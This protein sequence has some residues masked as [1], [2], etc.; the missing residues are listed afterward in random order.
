MLTLLQIRDFAIVEAVE[1]QFRPGFTALTGET[2][3]GKSILVDA[4]LLAIG[5]RGDSTVVRHGA[6]RTQI[7]AGFDV[8]GNAAA[9]AWLEEQSIDVQ[10]ECLLRR[11]VGTDGRS[12]AW[13]NGQSMPI[14]ALR[15][16]GDLLVEVHGQL[17]FQSLARRGYQR[18]LLDA[19]GDLA[20]EA[21]AVRAAW[22]EWRSAEAARVD[23]A[24]RARDREAR[25]DLLTHYVAELDALD[26]G[27]DEAADLQQERRRGA[28]LG[29]LAEGA[30]RLQD[31]LGVEGDGA[32]GALGRSQAL[33]RP[34][35]VL[36]ES[37]GDAQ[38]LVDEAAIACREA[39]G[40]L[41]HFA[42]SLN[43]DPTRLETVEARLSAFEATARKHRVD[44]AELPALR[45]RLAGELAELSDAG[46]HLAGLE[47]RVEQ[48]LTQYHAAARELT[49]GR[50]GAAVRLDATITALMQGLGMGGGVF[51]TRIEVPDPPPVGEHGADEIEFEVSANPGQPLRALARVA[52]GG[53]LSRMSLA[54]QVATLGADRPP[55]L[56]FDEVDA[57]VGGAVAE[58][59]G[60]SA[61]C[62]GPDGPGAVRNAPGAGRRT[63]RPADARRQAHRRLHDAHLTGDAR[64]RVTGPGDRPDARWRA[65]DGSDSRPRPRD[66]RGRARGRSGAAAYFRCK[67]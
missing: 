25:L 30:A 17:E 64:R 46:L 58:M 2:G 34:L 57:G 37:L 35:V 67:R 51:T 52:S 9:R 59:V 13:I 31:L 65:P 4:L 32:A 28:S 20:A 62:P 39:L 54:L 19:S 50:R 22:Q 10:E 44:V 43:A 41:A 55:C 15:E 48:A 60:R 23:L 11:V 66:A 45:V 47:R 6:E 38:R 8:S 27:P 42:D 53:E 7:T 21:S 56:V 33:L 26:P 36:D 63:G 12:R 5:G 24:R 16:L 40:S 29:R 49:A 14:T 18:D 1:I 61:R 3:A